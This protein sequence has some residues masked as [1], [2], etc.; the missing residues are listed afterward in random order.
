MTS[1]TRRDYTLWRNSLGTAVAKGTAA[2]GDG[3]GQITLAD[4]EVWKQHFGAVLPPATG[5][6]ANVPEP[7]AG[8]L[9]LLG[10]C[11]CWFR[12]GRR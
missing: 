2:D 11:A 6:A 8:L 9:A 4:Y 7:A 10:W 1:S 3:D 12:R 5:R